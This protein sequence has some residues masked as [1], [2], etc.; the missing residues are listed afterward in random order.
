MAFGFVRINA[1]ADC[2]EF[3]GRFMI[4]S[5]GEK[6]LTGKT[7]K[8]SR[9]G[10]RVLKAC[11]TTNCH[12]TFI[13]VFCGLFDWSP[14]SPVTNNQLVHFHYPL[15]ITWEW[16]RY[17]LGSKSTFAQSC[18]RE[19]SQTAGNQIGN[20]LTRSKRDSPGELFQ[21]L[22]KLHNPFDKTWRKPYRKLPH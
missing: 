22:F 9:V 18:R 8:N 11:M 6:S 5:A 2:E 13:I 19:D 10:T 12:P 3:C 17:S 1:D 7:S 21:T 4:K 16:T 20:F 14:L 15:H